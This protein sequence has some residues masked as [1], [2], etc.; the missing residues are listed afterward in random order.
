VRRIERR[1]E[2]LQSAS[3]ILEGGPQDV[4]YVGFGYPALNK[5]SEPPQLQYET[6]KG[7]IQGFSVLSSRNYFDAAQVFVSTNEKLEKSL[8]LR[9][10]PMNFAIVLKYNDGVVLRVPVEGN[11]VRSEKAVL[12]DGYSLR[13]EK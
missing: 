12:P 13:V 4:R 1:L 6:D 3:N 5:P 2:S 9:G 11:A 8:D 7:I 10:S